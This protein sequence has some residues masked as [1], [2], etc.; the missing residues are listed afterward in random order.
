MCSFSLTSSIMVS[1]ASDSS[2]L[3]ASLATMFLSLRQYSLSCNTHKQQS[4]LP[5][6]LHDSLVCGLDWFELKVVLMHLMIKD[7]IHSA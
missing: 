6:R 2:A 5:H 7:V 3:V 4:A 1:M